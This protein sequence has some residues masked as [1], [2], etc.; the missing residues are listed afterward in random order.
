MA[1]T[2]YITL[3]EIVF[4]DEFCFILDQQAWLDF[5]WSYSWCY[6]SLKQQSAGRHDTL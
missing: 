5:S 2:S 4:S 1:R 6:S 3:D